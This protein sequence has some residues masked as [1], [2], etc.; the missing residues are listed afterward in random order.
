MNTKQRNEILNKIQNINQHD[1]DSIIAK[2]FPNSENLNEECIGQF[3][4]PEFKSYLK[5]AIKQLESE[6][7]SDD[8]HFLQ[9]SAVNVTKSGDIIDLSQTL[10]NI[11]AYLSRN[12]LQHIE[13]NLKNLINYQIAYGFWN[14]SK[15]KIHNVAPL[16]IKKSKENLM[17]LQEQVKLQI[18]HLTKQKEEVDKIKQ[19]FSMFI[20]T[21]KGE[22]SEIESLLSQV[23][24]NANTINTLLQDSQANKGKIEEVLNTQNKLLDDVRTRIETERNKYEEFEKK[25]LKTEESL[26]STL[27]EAEKKFKAFEEHFNFIESKKND[28]LKLTGY[29]ADGS[30]G[31]KF[32]ARQIELKKSIL[33]WG[34]AV[35]ISVVGTGVWVYLVFTRFASVSETEW[36]GLIINILKTVPAFL[37]MGFTIK[38][39]VKERSLQEEYAYRAAVAM[40]ITAYSEM[41]KDSDS[42]NN[43]S[44]QKMLL[45]AITKVYASPR[46]HRD[47]E[48]RI[49]SMSTR[50]L[51]E[52]VKELT[53]TVKEIKNDVL[54]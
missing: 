9:T 11:N 31:S 34:I 8:F 44:R 25:N 6:I 24:G 30:L 38:Q 22:W 1:L 10:E 42:E 35:L 50:D 2:A 32:F 12:E 17:T 48:D 15:A 37:L 53:S 33:I 39:Y 4:A 49:F 26:K 41:L 47:R 36:I 27:S 16:E 40:T 20:N 28:I 23:K 45:D 5:R 54:K 14:K 18:N 19:E 13:G 43:L 7:N 46:I 21:K 29:A 52:A 51:R 3:N